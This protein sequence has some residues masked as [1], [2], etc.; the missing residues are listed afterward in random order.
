[1]SVHDNGPGLPLRVLQRSQDYDVRVSNKTNYVS[2][3]RGQ[4]GNAW[5]CLWAVG[6]VLDGREGVVE[7][8]SHGQCHRVVVRLDA[9]VG[10]PKFETTSEP[11]NIRN[12]TFVRLV[13]PSV[14]LFPN[15]A[16]MARFL[17]SG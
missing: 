8:A 17:C 13:W 10:T 7:V 6:V 9:I 15:F 3:T 5:K 1:V 11:C 14:A 4:L 16:E 12:G 2:P